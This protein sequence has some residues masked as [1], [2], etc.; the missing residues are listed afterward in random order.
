VSVW[1]LCSRIEVI[2]MRPWKAVVGVGAACAACCA[3]PLFGGVAALTAGSTALAALGSAL[4]ACADEFVPL[5]GVLLALAAAGG[6]L[7]WWHRRAARKVQAQTS[8]GGGC[9]AS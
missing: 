4:L 7:V 9:S 1:A 3:I 5:A 2:H 8:C 6:G